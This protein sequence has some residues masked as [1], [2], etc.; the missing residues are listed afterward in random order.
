[1]QKLRDYAFLK[2]SV[3]TGEKGK[4]GGYHHLQ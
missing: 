4:G 2:T 3:E 1:M